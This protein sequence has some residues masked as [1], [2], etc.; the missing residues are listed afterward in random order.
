MSPRRHVRLVAL[1]LLNH[2]LAE[3]FY[4]HLGGVIGKSYKRRVVLYIEAGTTHQDTYII[5]I[6]ICSRIKTTELGGG[7]TESEVDG[8]M[9]GIA[10]LFNKI[11]FKKNPTGA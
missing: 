3:M 2:G 6:Y 11:K 7:G 9:N 8:I 1:Q 5:Y 4:P 10:K